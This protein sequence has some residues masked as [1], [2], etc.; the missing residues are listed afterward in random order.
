LVH[1]KWSVRDDVGFIELWHD[2]VPQTF[3]EPCARQT[4]CTV[5]TLMPGGDA[6]YFK[7]GYEPGRV[8]VGEQGRGPA[9]AV[10]PDQHPPVVAD[11]AAQLRDQSAQLDGQGG[12]GFGST[13]SSGSPAVSDTQLSTVAGAGDFNRGTWVLAILRV[14][15]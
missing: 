7:Q 10:E 13:T 11:Q 3:G 1:I 8:K 4:R 2:G 14:P 6:V 9:A 5:R 12:G 15:A